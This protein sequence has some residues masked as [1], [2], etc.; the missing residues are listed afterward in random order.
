MCQ[1]AFNNFIIRNNTFISKT[2]IANTI[3]SYSIKAKSIAEG[4]SFTDLL[5]A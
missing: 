4:E 5:Y 1:L 3:S 2:S